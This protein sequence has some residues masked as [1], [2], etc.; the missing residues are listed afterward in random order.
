MSLPCFPTAVHET[1][2]F[3][4]QGSSGWFPWLDGTMRRCDSLSPLSPHF[5]SLVWRYHRC[6][7]CLSRTAQDAKLW[8]K[9][10]PSRPGGAGR[11]RRD[12]GAEA[13]VVS[14]AIGSPR[15]SRLRRRV[16]V[17][18]PSVP[19]GPRGPDTRCDATPGGGGRG[20]RIVSCVPYSIL[21]SW[22]STPPP[23]VNGSAGMARSIMRSWKSGRGRIA[24]RLGLPRSSSKSR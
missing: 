22:D 23:C 16:G 9:P 15:G 7:P 20:G 17:A 18:R 24:S 13:A 3:P 1:V 10:G 4:P 8:V 5:I 19:C 12:G 11:D 21:G 14:V 6:V 2:P